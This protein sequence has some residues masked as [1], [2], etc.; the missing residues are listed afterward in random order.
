MLDRFG[1]TRKV[2]AMTEFSE[3]IIIDAPQEQVW[4]TLADIGSIHIWNPGVVYS[5][6]T[7]PGEVGL[8]ACRRCEFGGRNYLDEEIVAFEPNVRM[9]I[10][11]TDTNLPFE[12]ADIRFVLEG[13][14]GRTEV[15]VSPEYELK[16]GWLGRCLD[17]LFVRA[18]YQKG[19]RTLLQGLKRHVERNRV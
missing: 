19:M 6:Q 16:F 9:T 14:D 8:G 2:H 3:N 13:Q 15:S 1:F 4:A 7:T 10:R 12:A 5:R 17:R 11:I 18:R